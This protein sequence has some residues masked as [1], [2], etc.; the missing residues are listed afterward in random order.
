MPFNEHKTIIK[1]RLKKAHERFLV[2]FVQ[3]M[4][5]FGLLL[6]FALLV[7]YCDPNITG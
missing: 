7:W 3:L 5:I 1:V 6:M 2:E 4:T